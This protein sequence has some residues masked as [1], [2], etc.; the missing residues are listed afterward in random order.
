MN[1]RFRDTVKN[2]KIVI[3]INDSEQDLENNLHF[4]FDYFRFLAV[5]AEIPFS[6]TTKNSD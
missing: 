4:M 3:R 1:S 6:N 2:S 5:H